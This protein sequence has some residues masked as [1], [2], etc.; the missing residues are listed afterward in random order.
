MSIIRKTSTIAGSSSLSK[1]RSPH[2]KSVTLLEASSLKLSSESP[3]RS[4]RLESNSSGFHQHGEP[5]ADE[6]SSST[7]LEQDIEDAVETQESTRTAKPLIPSRKRKV[8]TSTNTRSPRKVK[9]IRLALD[10]PHPPPENWRETYASVK[11]MRKDGGAP[12]DE[13]GCHMA[14]GPVE[15]PKVCDDLFQ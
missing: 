13:M 5:D 6:K 10:V 2:H 3:R 11:E 15:D 7:D 4:S 9:A 1:R 14:G 8:T 12:V